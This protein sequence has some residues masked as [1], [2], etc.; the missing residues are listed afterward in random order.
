VVEYP[1]IA[2]SEMSVAIIINPV[3]GGRRESVGARVDLARRVAAESGET[4]DVVV[5]EARGHARAL[6]HAARA[7][8]ARVIVAWGGDGTVNE[9]AGEVA[10]SNLPIG[11][12]PAGSGN[13]LARELG[14]RA[15]PRA[16]LRTALEGRPRPIDVGEISNRLF[17]NLAGVGFDAH[18][19]ACFNAPG[20]RLRGVSGYILQT[21]RSLVG[22]RPRQYRLA[23]GGQ[24][25]SV[26]ALFIVIANGTQFGNGMLIAPGARVD[27][28]ALDVVVVEERSRAATICRVPWLLCRSIHRV[29]VWSSRRTAAVAI[30]CDEPMVFHV[31]GEIVQ[32]G[33]TIEARIHPHA[34]KVMV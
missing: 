24:S 34:L 22:Y 12:V 3:A 13:G 6:A 10:F 17:V 26:Q 28:G 32:G 23:I 33:T 29:P 19:A 27:D 25:T 11:I 14:L 4:A 2:T 20:N 31:D 1:A 18:V 7:N 15:K 9:I 5:T 30:A 8:G 21:A 16:A